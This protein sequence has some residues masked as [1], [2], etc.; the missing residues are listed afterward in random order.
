MLVH[1]NKKPLTRNIL[2]LREAITK[3]VKDN[4]QAACRRL[5]ILRTHQTGGRESRIAFNINTRI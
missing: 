3:N 5:V 4:L 1:T 2:V